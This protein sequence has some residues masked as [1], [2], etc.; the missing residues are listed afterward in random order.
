MAPADPLPPLT[1]VV[2]A[3]GAG[4]RMGA[5]KATLVV[6]GQRLVDR[7][8][9]TLRPICATVLVASGDGRRLCVPGTWEIADAVPGSG[10]LGG[11]LAGLDRAPTRLVAV[12]AVDLPDADPRL[13][14]RLA[15]LH[16]GEAAVIPRTGARLQ[17][18]HAVWDRSAAT[19]LRRALGEGERGVQRLLAR[20]PVRVVEVPGDGYARNLNTPAGLA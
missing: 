12:L 18:L 16:R 5:D 11:L 13:L 1:G 6:G 2:L 8:V 7:A 20:L 4:R 10:P 14:A 9:A 3:G 17:P 15:G 19:E